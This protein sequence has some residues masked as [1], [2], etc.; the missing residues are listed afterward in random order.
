MPVMGHAA[1]CV[2]ANGLPHGHPKG[3]MR[4]L[5]TGKPRAETASR[6]A[7]T[8][9]WHPPGSGVCPDEPTFLHM[10]SGDGGAAV[11]E[12]T[13]DGSGARQPASDQDKSTDT[14]SFTF[15]STSQTQDGSRPP[16]TG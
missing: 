5:M 4:M 10:M 9:A 13:G 1:S 3:S 16:K 2:A 14:R 15:F 6:T 11:I 8:S 12:G 7:P